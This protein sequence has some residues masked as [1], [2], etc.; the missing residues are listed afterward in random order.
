MKKYIWTGTVVLAIIVLVLIIS[1][2]SSLMV[3][4][5]PTIKIGFIA[6]LS[7]DSAAYGEPIKNSVGLAVDEINRSGGIDGKQIQMIYEDGKCDGKDAATAAQKLVGVDKV[8]YI[9][10]GFCSGEV[11]GE[12]PITSP[13]KVFVISYAASAAK[14]SGI[15]DYFIRNNPSDAI[16]GSILADYLSKSYK[17]AAI[18]SEQTD[19]AQGVRDVFA[20]EAQKNGLKIVDSENYA[21][22]DIDFRSELLKIKSHKPDVL[23][24]NS[25]T[26]KDAVR[27][28]E[29]ARQLGITLQFAN[30]LLCSDPVVYTA[31]QATE[32]MICVNL[33]GLPG[34][35]GQEFINKYKAKY[36]STPNFPLYAGAAYDD[37]YLLKQAISA[38]GG[39]STKVM[40][41][42]RSLPSYTG[43]IGTYHFDSKG[44]LV[45]AGLILQKVLNK[46]PVNI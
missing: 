16:T 41:Y 19:Y 8:R 18:I 21:T 25:Q 37:I 9:V 44:D 29:E 15:S 33:A 2:V 46:E 27:I 36:D 45:G 35:S 10:G 13:T 6:P 31:G 11:F 24:I 12:V 4:G 28:A 5:D 34:V 7:G 43:T 40:R 39:D 32:G 23:F 14:L 38:V 3:K 22:G 17:T 42:L 26:G 30:T 20:A 1:G